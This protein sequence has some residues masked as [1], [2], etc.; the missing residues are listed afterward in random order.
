MTTEY[1]RY[2]HWQ[3]L[4]QRLQDPV[5]AERFSSLF[6]KWGTEPANPADFPFDDRLRCKK[7][8]VVFTSMTVRNWG[9]CP[10][11]CRPKTDAEVALELL[12]RLFQQRQTE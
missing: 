7:C 8:G 9:R 1:R 12:E 3:K 6:R 5:A 4:W 2:R 10:K 11:G